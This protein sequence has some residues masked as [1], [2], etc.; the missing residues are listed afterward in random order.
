MEVLLYL[1]FKW[2]QQRTRAGEMEKW[3]LVHKAR[4]VIVIDMWF[5]AN[6]DHRK[7]HKLRKKI[8]TAYELYYQSVWFESFNFF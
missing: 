1:D 7:N 3:S 5:S 4:R 2:I 8:Q 6:S